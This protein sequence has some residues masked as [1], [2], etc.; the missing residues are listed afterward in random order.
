MRGL[1]NKTGT[2]N[3]VF[4]IKIRYR[5]EGPGFNPWN[6][7]DVF[8]TPKPLSLWRSPNLLYSRYRRTF[9]VVGKL[10]SEF[11]HLSPSTAE[12]KNECSYTSSHPIRLHDVGRNNFNF[13]FKEDENVKYMNFFICSIFKDGVNNMPY[14][15]YFGGMYDRTWKEVTV[16]CF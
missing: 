16:I 14:I 11:N 6:R 2:R 8:S 10:G 13:T 5:L 7:Q 1:Q 4:V 15:V 3:I 9:P 12:A